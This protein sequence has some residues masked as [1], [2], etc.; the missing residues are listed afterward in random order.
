MQ[1]DK[2]VFSGR[3]MTMAPPKNTGVALLSNVRSK[4]DSE[5]VR[6]RTTYKCSNEKCKEMGDFRCG[7]NV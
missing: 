5:T 6:T 4:D 3:R 7:D 1:L 2:G